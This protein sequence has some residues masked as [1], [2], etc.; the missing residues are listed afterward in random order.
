VSRRT[1]SAACLRRRAALA[2]V[3]LAAAAVL[4]AC[5]AT[6]HP[7]AAAVVGDTRIT[8]ASLQSHVTAFRTALAAQSGSSTEGS[9][10]VR[11]TLQVLVEA[12]L[13]DDALAAK[14]LTVSAA[15]VQQAHTQAVAQ[16]GSEAALEQ[17]FL[18]QLGLAPSDMDTYFRMAVGEQKLLAA[19]G[20]SPASSQADSALQSILSDAAKR[21]GVSV[22]PRYG[23][24]DA[25]AAVVN[26]AAE[27]WVKATGSA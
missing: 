11:H 19:A 4:T 7:G 15:E 3:G 22:N 14:G 20:V 25:G 8:T 26:A 21:V 23:S 27:P 9:G 12:Q 5:G 18:A 2:S 17:A 6:A 24:W 10:L 16:T 13:V 1:E